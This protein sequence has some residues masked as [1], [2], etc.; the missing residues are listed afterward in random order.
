MVS[1]AEIYYWL[2]VGLPIVLVLLYLYTFCKIKNSSKLNFI[3]KLTIALM[4]SS[5]ASITFAYL[6]IKADGDE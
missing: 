3:T 6:T 1:F 2:K 4:I 5:I